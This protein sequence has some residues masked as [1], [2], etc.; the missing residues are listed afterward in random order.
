M[1]HA[2]RGIHTRLS[3]K[4]HYCHFPVMR[5]PCPEGEVICRRF[6]KDAM[7]L[8]LLLVGTFIG[9]L[10]A[11]A[12]WMMG[13]TLMQ[14]LLVLSLTGVTATLALGT[15]RMRGDAECDDQRVTA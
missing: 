11:G 2:L 13:A 15:L 7:M 4:P 12:A 6:G 8:G 3:E 9:Y 5:W 14:A 1:R 10:F